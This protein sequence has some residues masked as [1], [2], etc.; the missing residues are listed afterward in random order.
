M[1]KRM[2]LVPES[3][4]K[5]SQPQQEHTVQSIAP[6]ITVVEPPQAKQDPLA[7]LAQLLPKSYRS[8]ARILL[9]YLEGHLKLNSQQRVLYPP[10]DQPGSHILDLV[11]YYVS[12]WHTD[13]PL[14]APKFAKLMTQAGVPT[15]AIAKKTQPMSSKWQRL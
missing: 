14:D 9:H 1:A 3:W 7:D 6:S 10:N 4:L 11:K 2:A 15:S 5:V 12:T 8:R 13:R